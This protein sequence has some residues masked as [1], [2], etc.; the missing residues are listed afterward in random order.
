MLRKSM[1][2]L[3]VTGSLLFGMTAYAAA[4]PSDHAFDNKIVKRI[5]VDN[6]YKTIELLSEEPRVAGTVAEDKAVE[7]IE[8]QFKSFGYDTRVQP[9][10]MFQYNPPTTVELSVDGLGDTDFA[11][12][13]FTYGVNGDVTGQLVYIGLG[14]PEDVE[15]LDLS[16]KIAL[17]K[18]GSYTFAEKIFNAA[19]AGAEAVIL[20]NNTSG[21]I[22]G[23][24][25][26][27]S[28]DYVPAVAIGRD[29]GEQ[30]ADRL[31]AGEE[32]T[33][34]V[35]IAGAKVERQTSHNVIATKKPNRNKD[36][37]Q[38]VIVGA[39][40]DSVEGAPGANDDAS[41]TATVL[42]LARVMSNM[43]I[44][45]ELRFITFGAEENGLIG[46][47]AYAES[48]TEDE[49]DRIV[50]QF[51]MDMVGSRDAGELIMYTVDGE[52]NIV[53][54]LGAAAGARLSGV[55]NYG[56]EGRSDHVPFAELGIPSALFIHAPVEPWYHTPEDT[57]DKISREKLQQV[58]EIV[59]AAVYQ[60]ARLDTPALEHA[61]VA[62]KPVDYEFEER[63]LE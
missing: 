51:Q 52:K 7:Y 45:T 40:H 2:S 13:T 17:V 33:A 10:E 27:P 15:G 22:N 62:P 8:K 48:L 47:Y 1:V 44:D 25:G 36:T 4:N 12:D 49:L 30:L 9:F 34:H 26:E 39:H 24:L 38:I 53:T 21:G 23:T 42:E 46:S 31:A 57:I 56:Q 55:V 6:I 43:P 58:A 63:E 35:K 54:D 60:I 41:G 50:G 19:G 5:K 59:G 29:L 18:R 14:G 11:P 20:F 28:D 16:G 3:A 61:R 37:G 32:L